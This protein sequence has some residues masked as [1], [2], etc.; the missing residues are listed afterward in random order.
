[1]V[2]DAALAQTQ[3]LDELDELLTL[4]KLSESK[5]SASQ[6]ERVEEILRSVRER[7]ERAAASIY[8]LRAS[9]KQATEV[10]GRVLSSIWAQVKENPSTC[11]FDTEVTLLQA[12]F[13][14]DAAHAATLNAQGHQRFQ[15]FRNWRNVKKVSQEMQMDSTGEPADVREAAQAKQNPIATVGQ[16]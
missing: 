6:N 13:T 11:R 9:N 2:F 16:A 8:T 4:I 3:M 7:S 12:P 14:M 10:Y 5:R 15:Q 1:M